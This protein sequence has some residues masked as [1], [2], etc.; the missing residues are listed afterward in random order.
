MS[1]TPPQPQPQPA[2]QPPQGPAFDPNAAH[3]QKP[4]LRPIR[5]FA[6]MGQ[7]PDG[8]QHQ[9]LG[10]SDARQIT[11]RVVMTIP[12]VQLILPLMDGSRDLDQIIS[13]VGRGLTR[14]FM[15]PLVAQLDDAGLI[16]GPRFEGLLA[17]MRKEFDSSTHLPPGSTA[18]FIEAV[19]KQAEQN[20]EIAPTAREAEKD[21]FGAKRLRTLLDHWMDEALRDEDDPSF[22]RLPSAI[23]APHLDYG[24]GWENYALVYGRMRVVD[25]P[26]R[27]IILGTNHFGMSTGVAVCDKGFRTPLGECDVDSQIVD[28]LKASLGPAVVEHRYDHEREHSIELH[29]P[30]IQ[31]VF[32]QGENG[33]FPK[34]VGILVHDPC[35]KNGESYDGKGVALSPFIAALK[36]AIKKAGGRTLVVASA[37]LSHV[38]PAF[39]DK[40]TLAD[41]NEQGM[42][43]RNKTFAHDQEMLG[44]LTGG[45]PQE[46]VSAMAWQKNP[47]RWCSVGNLVATT[48]VTEPSEVRLLNYAAAVDPQGATMVCSAA[49]A[50]W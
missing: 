48:M 16:E 43:A 38:G 2:S 15:E 3:H 41:D 20:G 31:H 4:R 45:K 40:F 34:V 25:R 30:W 26:D 10:L 8:T 22:D 33:K 49:M 35:V 12:A 36:D 42:E 23:V 44:H 7:A 39:G 50:M 14:E 18:A 11:D 19:V 46:L 6:A 13:Q 17:Q 27:V 37:D 29:I 24:R 28:S 21:E 5:G 1:Q 9:M 47:T 32:G